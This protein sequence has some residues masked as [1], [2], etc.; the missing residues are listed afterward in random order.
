MT[1]DFGRFPTFSTRALEAL[2][3]NLELSRRSIGVRHSQ[4]Q[5]HYAALRFLWIVRRVPP[6]PP[7]ERVGHAATSRFSEFVFESLNG[8]FLLFGRTNALDLQPDARSFSPLSAAARDAPL[9]RAIKMFSSRTA[10]CFTATHAALRSGD[11][12]GDCQTHTQ[13]RSLCA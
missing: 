3:G 8:V 7:R 2:M 4:R 5:N 6:P 10:V 1:Y 13:V 12:A 11:A 9:D